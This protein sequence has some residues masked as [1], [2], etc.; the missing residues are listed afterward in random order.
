MEKNKLYKPIRER[1]YEHR[2][3]EAKSQWATKR[4]EKMS[5]VRDVSVLSANA[6]KT[7]SFS[8]PPL[9]ERNKICKY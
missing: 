3:N 9:A 7:E 5:K 4:V 1:G 6:S 8:Q 2:F